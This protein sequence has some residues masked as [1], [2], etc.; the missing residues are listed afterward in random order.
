LNP[1]FMTMAAVQPCFFEFPV[2]T[3]ETGWPENSDIFNTGSILL[4]DK[5]L[6]WT[7][8]DVVKYVRNR[9]ASKKAGHAGT[10]DPLATGLLIVC[11]GKATKII[12][13]IQDM[14]KTYEAVIRFGA[15]TPSYDA[16]TEPDETADWAHISNS[17]LKKIIHEKFSGIIQQKPPLYSAKK[18]SGKRLYQY[19]REGVEVEV[20]TRPVTIHQIEIVEINMPE[21]TFIVRCGKGTYIRSLAH[22]L[23][24]ALNSRAYLSQLRRTETGDFNVSLAFVPSMIDALKRKVKYE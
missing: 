7:S 15:S 11:T 24:L 12:S 13:Q 21:V 20:K 4:L 22:D 3:C 14:P 2:I 23:G 10:L 18:V 8:F 6:E 16:A 19:A 1:L 9:V 5:P 17:G